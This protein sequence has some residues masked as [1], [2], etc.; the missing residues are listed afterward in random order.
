[1]GAVAGYVYPMYPCQQAGANSQK[2]YV[3]GMDF[4]K[5]Y[6]PLQCIPHGADMD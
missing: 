4:A 2:T 1:M 3:F 6:V 5:N